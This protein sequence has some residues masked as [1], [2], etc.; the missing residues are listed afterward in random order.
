MESYLEAMKAGADDFIAKPPD[1]EQ[2]AARL[3]VAERIVGVQNHVKRLEAVMSV[4]SYCKNVREERNQWVGMEQ[5]VAS[6][7]GTNPSHTVC[8]T[9]YATKVKPEL[10]QLGIK[11][12]ESKL[13]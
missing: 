8:P 7:L 11:V 12:D 9:C 3:L 4:C 6:H 10:D 2:L 1:E 13:W 5:Y